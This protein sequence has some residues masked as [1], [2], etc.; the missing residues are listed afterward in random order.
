MYGAIIAGGK[1]LFAESDITHDPFSLPPPPP[2]ATSV[3]D[4]G[5]TLTLLVA[6]FIGLF[7]FVSGKRGRSFI[8]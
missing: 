4:S 5:T 6:V 1:L 7:G 8:V 2:T 3:P